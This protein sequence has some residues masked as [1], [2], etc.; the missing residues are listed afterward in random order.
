MNRYVTN[1]L[2]VKKFFEIPQFYFKLDNT[3]SKGPRFVK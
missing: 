1:R 2:K 3:N